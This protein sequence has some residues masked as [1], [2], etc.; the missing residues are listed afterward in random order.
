MLHV[1]CF[2]LFPDCDIHVQVRTGLSAKSSP[3]SP[4]ATCWGRMSNLAQNRPGPHLASR[5][6][7]SQSR[8]GNCCLSVSGSAHCNSSHSSLVACLH[9]IPNLQVCFHSVPTLVLT[10][11]GCLGP[12][13]PHHMPQQPAGFLHAIPT[14]QE[15]APATLMCNSP[16]RLTVNRMIAPPRCCGALRHRRLTSLAGEAVER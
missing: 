11:Q 12:G 8:L 9:T 13:L 14:L 6:G 10:L 16:A 15:I 3:G 7:M 4:Q 2:F 1:T 5:L